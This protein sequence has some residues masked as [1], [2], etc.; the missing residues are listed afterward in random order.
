MSTEYSVTDKEAYLDRVSKSVPNAFQTWAELLVEK[1][2][3][4]LLYGISY[5]W[6]VRNQ[7]GMIAEAWV[8]NPSWVKP[9]FTDHYASTYEINHPERGHFFLSAEEVRVTGECK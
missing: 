1:N 8:L 2:V 4:E 9:H 6:L 5:V 7:H 3:Y